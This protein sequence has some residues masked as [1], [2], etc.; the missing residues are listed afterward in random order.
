MSYEIT[1]KLAQA[2]ENTFTGTAHSRLIGASEHE[3]PVKLY[4]VRFE[5]AAR[6]NWHIHSG[7]Q[8][9]VVCAG[10]CRYQ[11]EGE[12]VREAVAGESVR[13]EPGER[14]WHGASP[15]EPT[16]HIAVNLDNSKTTW[17]ERVTD[18]EY[19]GE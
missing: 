17:L 13:F 6:T 2:D 4:Y 5:L 1:W 8:I 10:R 9:V 16:E 12:G 19:R 15:A 3:V 7:V 11:R 18:A 14:H